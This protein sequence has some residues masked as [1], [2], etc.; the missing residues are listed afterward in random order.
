MLTNIRAG[1]ENLRSMNFLNRNLQKDLKHA[2]AVVQE[3]RTEKAELKE[4]L[5][6]CK[7]KNGEHVQK[8]Q[9]LECLQ[10][11]MKALVNNIIH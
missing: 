2:K 8:I 7:Q 6:K 10:K 3:L 11:N 1:E 5:K 4:N 9:R